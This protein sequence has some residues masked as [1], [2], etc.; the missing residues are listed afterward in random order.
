MVDTH[1]VEDGCIEVVHMHWVPGNIVTIIVGLA[2]DQTSSNPG[3][4]Q[5][6]R[7]AAGMVVPTIIVSGEGTLGVHGPTKFTSPYDQCVLKQ[8]TLL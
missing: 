1:Q 7:E 4:G 2:V 8:P 3:A 6:G 5:Q